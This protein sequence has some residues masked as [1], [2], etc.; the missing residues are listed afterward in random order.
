MDID[1]LRVVVLAA[2]SVAAG[3]AAYKS[4]GDK[5]F[6]FWLVCVGCA[7]GAAG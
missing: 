7:L 6:G 4:S 5:A 1:M 2:G 3:V